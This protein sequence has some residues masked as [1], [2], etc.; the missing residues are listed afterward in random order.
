MEYPLIK[1][2]KIPDGIVQKW[3]RTVDLLAEVIDVPAA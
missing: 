3:Q 1:E 2:I